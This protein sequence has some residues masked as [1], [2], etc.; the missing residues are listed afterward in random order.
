LYRYVSG[1]RLVGGFA[2]A[3]GVTGE[4]YTAGASDPVAGF[5]GP[6][7]SHMNADHEDSL[8]AVVGH[9]VG[10]TV[11]KAAIASLDA[12][13]MNMR[14]TRCGGVSLFEKQEAVC[15]LTPPV[16]KNLLCCFTTKV[17]C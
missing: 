3:G 17:F 6:I 14:V 1:A 12:L 5:S 13:G 11:D 7:A 16:Q 9:Y 10:L 2:R 15:T 4:E 8:L